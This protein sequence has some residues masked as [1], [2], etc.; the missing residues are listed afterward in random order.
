MIL[1]GWTCSGCSGFN[2]EAKG[3]LPNCRACGQERPG[4]ATVA[5][6]RALALSVLDGKPAN[7]SYVAAAIDF[8][9]LIENGTRT[10]RT[11]TEE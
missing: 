2:G 7:G 8:A 11:F 1:P 10:L 9:R 4:I 3:V 5:V 6:A